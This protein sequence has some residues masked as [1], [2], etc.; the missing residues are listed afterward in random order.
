[1][2]TVTAPASSNQETKSEDDVVANRPSQHAR[3]KNYKG[4]VAGMASGIAKL[5]GLLLYSHLPYQ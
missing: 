2:S 5:S 4:F 1:M 3:H